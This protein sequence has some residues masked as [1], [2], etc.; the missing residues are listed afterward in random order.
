MWGSYG[1]GYGSKGI[2][3]L[4]SFPSRTPCIPPPLRTS[5]YSTVLRGTP[6]VTR[7]SLGRNTALPLQ[8]GYPP[9]GGAGG[10]RGSRG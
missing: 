10:C 6:I 5:P 2:A 3:V 9:E 1:R 4:L 8:G 7:R